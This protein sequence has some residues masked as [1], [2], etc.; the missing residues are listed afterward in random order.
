[1]ARKLRRHALIEKIAGIAVKGRTMSVK[2]IEDKHNLDYWLKLQAKE[3]VELAKSEEIQFLH[4]KD[5]SEMEILEVARN[6]CLSVAA[7]NLKK[8]MQLHKAMQRLKK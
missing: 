3:A 6:A 2:E 8:A 4:F 5:I 7:E 1:M